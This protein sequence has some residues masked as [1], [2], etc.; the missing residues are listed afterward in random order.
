MAKTKKSTRS[1]GSNNSKG[2]S[3]THPA[4]NV[5]IASS[6]VSVKAP[7]ATRK[8]L[9]SKK[10][11]KSAATKTMEETA[12][13]QRA[14]S[15]PVDLD[16][17][18]DNLNRSSHYG[19][20][21]P[22]E[23]FDTVPL[24]ASPSMSVSSRANGDGNDYLPATLLN[25]DSPPKKSSKASSDSRK[26]VIEHKVKDKGQ[27]RSAIGGG[28]SL[29]CLV[30]PML[31]LLLLVAL[32][33]GASSVYGWLFKFPALNKQVK[34]LEEQISRLDDE[35][36]RLQ[37]ENNRYQFLNDKLNITVDDL[38]DVRDDLNITVSDLEDVASVLNTTRDQIVAEIGELQNQNYEYAQLNA[39]L[40]SNVQ[41]LAGEVSFFRDALDKL[42][43]EH[44][45]LQDTTTSLQ[46]LATKFA[47]TTIDQNETLTVLKET[48][49]GFQAENDRLEDFNEKLE[50]GLDY[51]NETLFA[52]GDLVESSAASIADLAEVLGERVQ[53]QQQSSLL[54]LEISYRQLLAGWDC[55][56]RDVFRS[57]AFGQD[58]DVFLP[59]KPSSV[60]PD[61]VG[62]YVDERI[63]SK[64]C[65]D[66]DDF[67]DYLSSSTN[68]GVTS[69]QLI[70]AVILYTEDALKYYFPSAQNDNNN[71]ILL[72]EWIDAGFR[73]DLLDVPYEVYRTS[74]NNGVA[75]RKNRFLRLGNRQ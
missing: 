38:E 44:S 41:E 43:D 37:T 16:E 30:K 69:N 45:I 74:G 70:R 21:S 12:P 11:Q 75:V 29:L 7:N 59:G 46:D 42:T 24:S 63:L 47:N 56:Y 28:G 50:A 40:Q 34:E 14:E 52:N 66:L 58:Y 53:Q 71:G 49:E 33:A 10:E 39:G 61:Q 3:S 13:R 54:Q 1:V 32:A 67:E 72:S 20:I 19:D 62:N 2:S 65:L 27:S 31:I 4:S 35:I 60:L 25:F 15:E 5:S 26:V 51:L 36:D 57:E 17:V 23:T 55:D 6:V 73:C 48:L 18:V 22:A 68:A 8:K 64:L 9:R